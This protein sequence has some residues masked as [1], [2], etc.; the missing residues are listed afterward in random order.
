VVRL[1]AAAPAVHMTMRVVH[2]AVLAPLC[3]RPPS[4]YFCAACWT[5]SNVAAGT[6]SQVAAVIDSACMPRAFTL[7]AEPTTDAGVRAEACWVVLNALTCGS[8]RQVEAL[9]RAGAVRALTA[10]LG[11]P[12][13]LSMAVDAL[14]KILAVGERLSSAAAAHMVSRGR[15]VAAAAPAAPASNSKGALAA[16]PAKASKKAGAAGPPYVASTALAAPIVGH[17]KPPLAVTV[18][19]IALA[20]PPATVASS[21]ASAPDSTRGS[22]SLGPVLVQPAA[23]GLQ[24]ASIGFSLPASAEPGG[25]KSVTSSSADGIKPTI[26]SPRDVAAAS[27]R[28]LCTDSAELMA[29]GSSS[30]A[31]VAPV[32]QGCGKCAHCTPIITTPPGG[33]ATAA[34]TFP[35]SW[36]PPTTVTLPLPAASMSSEEVLLFEAKLLLDTCRRELLSSS[37]QGGAL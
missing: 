23:G 37:R 14:E 35:L 17:A 34:G 6:P 28:A 27:S 5:L 30:L 18:L 36:M 15:G 24:R 3:S 2:G 13:M 10:L 19:P 22:P 20:G 1:T 16:P 32:S 25:G 33:G 21:S 9:V 12:S 26:V 11:D 7:C 29:G 8:E 4:H 31:S